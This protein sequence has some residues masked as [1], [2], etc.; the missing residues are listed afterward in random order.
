[1]RNTLAV[2]WI[3]INMCCDFPKLVKGGLVEEVGTAIKTR[4]HF[5]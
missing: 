2:L 1:M 4:Q 5:E 3:F